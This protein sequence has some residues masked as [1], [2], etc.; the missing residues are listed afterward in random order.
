M[1]NSVLAILGKITSLIIKIENTEGIAKY[2]A[3]FNFRLPSL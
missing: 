3:V 1:V 2:S